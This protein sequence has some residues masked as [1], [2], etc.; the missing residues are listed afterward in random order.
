M[1]FLLGGLYL[2]LLFH[3]GGFFLLSHLRAIFETC[4]VVVIVFPACAIFEM[5]IFT[6][7]CYF[8]NVALYLPVLFHKRGSLPARAVRGRRKVPVLLRG[9]VT[10]FDVA[11][12]RTRHT[13]RW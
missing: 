8:R 10:V 2:P 13:V 6:C 12:L 3:K 9:A 4:F 1:L 5:W 11:R 7:P